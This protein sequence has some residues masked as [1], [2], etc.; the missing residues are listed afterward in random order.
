[1]GGD[2]GPG[3]IVDG[4]LVAARHLQI[5]LLLAGDRATIERELS[6]HPGAAALDL[7]IIDT[8]GPFNAQRRESFNISFASGNFLFRYAFFIAARIP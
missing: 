7:R 1:M 5:G 8:P 6:R 2:D 4:A 3:T